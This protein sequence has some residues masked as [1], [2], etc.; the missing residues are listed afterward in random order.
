MAS[1]QTSGSRSKIRRAAKPS[2]ASVADLKRL[3]HE[4]SVHQIELEMQ[5]NELRSSEEKIRAIV[6]LSPDII[7][8]FDHEGRL[9]FN[10]AAAGKIH[11][12]GTRELDG[13]T[14]FDLI[15]PEDRRQ[16]QAAF[17]R[18]L[19]NQAEAET[20]RYRYRNVDGTFKWMEATARNELANPRIQ[21]VISVSRDIS[22]RVAAQTALAEAEERFRRFMDHSP[23]VIW[24]KDEAGRWVYLNRTFQHRFGARPEDWRGKKDSKFFPAP[25]ARK[26]R[27]H[28]RAVLKQGRAM[29]FIEESPGADGE[30]SQWLSIKFPLR[31]GAGK[32][33]I[34]GIALDITESRRNQESLRRSEERLRLSLE[35]SQAG[36]WSWEV[37]GDGF[38]WDDRFHRLYGFKPKEKKSLAAWLSRVHPEDRELLRARIRALVKPGR[39]IPWNEQFRVRLPRNR[40]KWML[41]LGRVERSA[42]GKALRVSGINLD[43]TRRKKTELALQASEGQYRRLYESMTDAFASV[44]MSGRIREANQAF[45]KMLGYSKPELLRLTYK[46]LT[47]RKWHALEAGIVRRQ[48]MKHGSSGVYEKEYRRKDGT[49]FPVEL[50]TFLIKDDRG[51]PTGMWAIIR[52]ITER[53]QAAEDMRQLNETLE[54]QVARRTAALRQSEQELG[55]FFANA[56]V[57]LMWVAKDGQVLRVNQAK[58]ELLGRTPKAVVGR[59]MQT[60]HSPSGPFEE[61]LERLACG[62]TVR[63]FRARILRPDGT[64][65]HVL[66]DANGLWQRK[67]LIHTRWFVRDI[68]RHVELEQEILSASEREQERIAHDLHDDLCQQL[69]GIQFLADTLSRDLSDRSRPESVPAK[70]IAHML[71]DTLRQTRELSHGLSPVAVAAGGLVTAL[72]QF[73]SRIEAIFH[74]ECRFTG[75]AVL[76]VPDHATGIHLYRI[77]QEAVNNAIHHGR[78]TRIEIGLSARQEKLTLVIRDNGSGFKPGQETQAG[79][80]LRVMRY[81]ANSL[82]GSVVVTPQAEGGTQ[83]V[84]TV[85][86]RQPTRKPEKSK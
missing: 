67:Q 1:G 7:S 44:S 58:L 45:S 86:S 19:N 41:I 23:M 13:Q 16:V 84:C 80:G 25:F 15:H 70:Q 43:I 40:V 85:P 31:D 83:V 54:Q 4:L 14:T 65:R 73:S 57:G 51:R 49:I 36:T 9:T 18:L 74:R 78:A 75:D 12:Y 52:D 63:G 46:D 10:S 81:R 5:N 30:A 2:A 77:A 11:G 61:L 53:K 50:R 59:R 26:Y 33:F 6:E 38:T 82:G 47:P 69:T 29:E 56:P 21:G 27:E 35:A 3:Q 64:F 39:E 62:E 42:S 24:M 8:I 22:E 32:R 72:R 76:S 48:V 20:V 60:F 68:T 66:I 28:D 55:D 79:M 17:A 71:Q 37:A 34:G